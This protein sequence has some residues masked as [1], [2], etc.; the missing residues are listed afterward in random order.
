[1][2]SCQYYCAT[3]AVCIGGAEE[4]MFI[5][6]LYQSSH[7]LVVRHSHRQ[8]TTL[9]LYVW[10]L[11]KTHQHHNVQ[12]NIYI[13]SY[14]LF[15][16]WNTLAGLVDYSSII[17]HTHRSTTIHLLF[18][19]RW[20]HYRRTN[21]PTPSYI[22]TDTKYILNRSIFYPWNRN[23]VYDLLCKAFTSTSKKL[24]IVLIV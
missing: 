24:F 15:V 20:D 5:G 1:M 11:F 16:F 23:F 7:G 19:L 18:R 3:N 12:R 17:S 2:Y 4:C 21:T 13:S 8:A 9:L 6:D 10:V 14:S 22:I